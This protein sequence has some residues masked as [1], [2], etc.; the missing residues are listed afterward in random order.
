MAILRSCG[1]RASL[2]LGH[3]RDGGSIQKLCRK[4][5]GKLEGGEIRKREGHTAR[6]RQLERLTIAPDSQWWWLS[7][8]ETERTLHLLQHHCFKFRG[9]TSCLANR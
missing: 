4:G 5:G 1:M 6:F 8:P 3:S 7:T 9:P 2:D